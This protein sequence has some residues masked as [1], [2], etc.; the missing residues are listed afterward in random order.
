MCFAEV[1]A[2]R[3]QKELID[4]AVSCTLGVLESAK[5]AGTIRRVVMLS[6]TGAFATPE[7]VGPGYVPE[8]ETVVSEASLNEYQGPPYSNTR[9]CLGPGGRDESFG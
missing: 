5:K 8:T 6:S 4:P 7:L 1:P 9:K 2:E 3:Q